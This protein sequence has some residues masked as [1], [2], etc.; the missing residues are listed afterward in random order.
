MTSY[1]SIPVLVLSAAMALPA[2]AASGR[3]VITTAQIAA[4]ISA[5]GATVSPQQVT[6]LAE[7]VA[8]TGNPALKVESIERWGDHRMK[9]RLA[10]ASSEE[11]L[12]FL[13]AVHWTDETAAQPLLANA[14][15][16]PA[17]ASPAKTGSNSFVLR[18]GAPAILLLDGDHLHIRL[19]VTC[20]ENGAAGQTIRVSSKDHL[21]TYSAEVVDG[22]TLRGRL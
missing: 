9:V 11:C 3:T 2:S 18:A 19:I 10:C 6:L 12:P 1:K 8:T 21:Q 7:V 16:S 4:A 15:R 14:D 20:L 22:T 5:S 13:V 17:S